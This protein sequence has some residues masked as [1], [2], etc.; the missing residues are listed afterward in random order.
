MMVYI[1]SPTGLLSLSVPKPSP[2]CY[3]LFDYAVQ[4]LCKFSSFVNDQLSSTS[5]S[6]GAK[7]QSNP[8]CIFFSLDYIINLVT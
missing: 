3:S 4:R 2:H 8:D 6:S 7:G 5:N 1:Q